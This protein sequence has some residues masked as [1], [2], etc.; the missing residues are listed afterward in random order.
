MDLY[1]TGGNFTA[2]RGTGIGQTE[3]EIVSAYRDMG[4][5]ASASGNRGLYQNDKGVGRILKTESG[6][7]IR[8]VCHTADSHT[9]QL[10]YTLNQYGVCTAI[11]TIY[12]P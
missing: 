6:K 11:E 2:P 10:D 7:I 12:L 3:T 4:Q 1:F 5:V 8:Y 9:W